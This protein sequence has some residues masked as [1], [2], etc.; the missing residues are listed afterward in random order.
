MILLSGDGLTIYHKFAIKAKYQGRI[1]SLTTSADFPH[2]PVPFPR[3]RY[4]FF[5]LRD[6]SYNDSCMPLRSFYRRNPLCF[7]CRDCVSMIFRDLASPDYWLSVLIGALT[8]VPISTNSLA[9]QE[10][11][12]DDEPE[13]SR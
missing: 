11:F 3:V 10:V 2:Q 8:G 12:D 1:A 9:S 5:R 7:M 4:P 13:S 6:F